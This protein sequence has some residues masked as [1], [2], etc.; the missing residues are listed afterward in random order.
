MK[1]LCLYTDCGPSYVRTGWGRVFAALGHDFAFWRP[2]AKPALDAFNEFE[3]DIF[4]GTTYDLDRAT[5]KA[6]QRRPEMK[7]ALFASAWGK[8]A[9][10][11]PESYPI[12]R[13]T[14]QEKATVTAL[15]ERT[16]R[17]HFVFSHVSNA[18][19][20]ALL[21]GWR[22]AGVEPAGILNAADTFGYAGGRFREELACDVGFI[23]GYWG[24]KARNL[25]KSILPLCHP[26]TGLRVKI[27]GNQNWPVAQYLGLLDDEDQKDVF[28][29]ATVCPNVSEPHSTDF[30]YD[31][32]ERPFKVLA[33][34]GFCLS[35]R[36]FEMD[37]VFPPGTLRQG[38]GPKEFIELVRWYVEHPDDRLPFIEKGRRHVLTHHTYFH[39]VGQ[40]MHLLGLPDQVMVCEDLHRKLVLGEEKR[41]PAPEG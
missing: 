1:V 25:D 17:P 38:R 26:S 7:V 27:W 5:F 24:Y 28:A 30:G 19:L 14:E 23:G 6:I 11:I 16:G 39:R 20:D 8:L 2:G 3:P 18:Y 22:E 34:G 41:T 31:I 4:L 36:V 10:E 40:M 13:V 32:V 33:A 37:E 35:D 9:Q 29:S 21:G 12:T 15:K